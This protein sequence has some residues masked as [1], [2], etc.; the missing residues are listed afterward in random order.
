[1]NDRKTEPPD[2]AV[3]V[4]LCYRD[5]RNPYFGNSVY[6]VVVPRKDCPCDNCYYGRD[7]LA[8]QVIDLQQ[9]VSEL[10]VRPNV[11]IVSASNPIQDEAS[12]CGLPAEN[13]EIGIQYHIG[14]EFESKTVV[15]LSAVCVQTS[16]SIAS[17]DYRKTSEG[18]S[19]AVINEIIPKSNPWVIVNKGTL[20]P[21]GSA[22]ENGMVTYWTEEQARRGCAEILR[23]MG[24]DVDCAP[25]SRI[26]H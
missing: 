19:M 5:P 11:A 22:S 6:D 25:L 15:F 8:V 14:C 4:N 9:K 26:K 18:T 2:Q 3:L 10:S 7:K 16:E 20:D 17:F 24:D 1:M 13:L 21:W 12:V 23:I